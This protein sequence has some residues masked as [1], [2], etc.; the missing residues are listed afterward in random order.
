M[1]SSSADEMRTQGDGHPLCHLDRPPILRRLQLG[2]F[3]LQLHLPGGC[4]AAAGQ[5]RGNALHQ[6]LLPPGC[7]LSG[8]RPIPPQHTH[9]HT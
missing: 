5:P 4:R 8:T 6:R 1:Q 3:Q 7:V 9:T 2:K